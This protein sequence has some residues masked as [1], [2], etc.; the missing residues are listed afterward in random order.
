MNRILESS[1]NYDLKFSDDKYDYYEVYNSEG[2]KEIGSPKWCIKEEDHW[3]KYVGYPS[4]S[5]RGNKFRKRNSW[6]YVIIKKDIYLPTSL[7]FDFGIHK[8]FNIKKFKYL[9][10][11][12]TPIDRIGI[13]WNED[14]S[15]FYSFD[16]NNIESIKN[17]KIQEMIGKIFNYRRKINA[18]RNFWG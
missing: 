11:N 17:S 16:D 1:I 3:N 5:S 18:H 9:Y 12:E 6:Q 2:I 13:T 15:K 7:S 4:Y 10:H 14:H 8:K